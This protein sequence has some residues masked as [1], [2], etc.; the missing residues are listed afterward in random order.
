MVT[1]QQ[2]SYIYRAYCISFL[3]G[4]L[5]R[6]VYSYET[7]VIS[8]LL[9]FTYVFFCNKSVFL[10]VNVTHDIH[11]LGKRT[12]ILIHWWAIL[13]RAYYGQLILIIGNTSL[14]FRFLAIITLA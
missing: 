13:L 10:Q 2:V 11:S 6:H 3:Y 14:I 5:Y 9:L 7:S 8:T 1:R 4:S 12:V